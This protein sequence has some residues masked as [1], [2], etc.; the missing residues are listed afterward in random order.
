MIKLLH[1]MTVTPELVA[2][3]DENGNDL[4]YLGL[5]TETGFQTPTETFTRNKGKSKAIH[6]TGLFNWTGT[7][8]YIEI[9]AGYSGTKNLWVWSGTFQK[10]ITLGCMKLPIL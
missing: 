6:I 3:E 7:V 10:K 1:L 2:A 5:L 8:C 4:V 9:P